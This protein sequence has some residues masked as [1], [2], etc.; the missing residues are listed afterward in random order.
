[1]ESFIQ[2]LFAE[3]IGGKN[4]GKDN[5]IYKFEKIK[6]AKR[7]A[8]EKNP[9]ISLIDF[10]VG[11]PDE[12]AFDVVIAALKKEADD[13]ANRGYSD[14]GIVEF[15]AAAVD[16]MKKVYGVTGLN[17]ETEVIHAIGSKS[18]LAM[19]PS[20]F[21]NPGDV[22]LMTVPGYPVFGTHTSWY[23]GEV[24]NLP[25]KKE[26]GFLPD[27]TGIPGD[28]LKRA[29]V[30]VLNYPNNPTGAVA[31]ES[32]YRE[33]IEFARRNSIVVVVDAAYA[34]LVYGGKPFSFLSIP[35]AKD[36]GVEIHSLSKA[37]NM[38]GWRMAFV[39]G[40][41]LVVRAFADVKD[42]YDSGQFKAVQK[43]GAAALQNPDITDKINVKYERRLKKLVA[44]L[45]RLGFEVEMPGGTFYLYVKIPRGVKG[46]RRFETAEEFSQFLI[47]EMLISTVPWDDVEPNV[48]FSATFEA[49]GIDDE[50]R[51]MKEVETRLAEYTFEF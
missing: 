38:T 36:V 12:K 40:N 26:N 44:L 37:F 17:P 32:F 6:R 24:Y 48:R 33:V 18:A 19:M 27:L 30:L 21:I 1:M 16:Y 34:A 11:E 22:A 13:P 49:S 28:I 9:G 43:A 2:N 47:K 14:N 4:Y 20:A 15:K 29:K 7:E 50:E 51:I 35:G 5:K 39:V 41:E 23:G 46:G 31:D 8:M 10:G 25:L 45:Q 3:R 42:N